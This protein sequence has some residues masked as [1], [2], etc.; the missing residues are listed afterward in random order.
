MINNVRSLTLSYKLWT[1]KGVKNHREF[2]ENFFVKF[3]MV[4]ISITL[5]A[6]WVNYKNRFAF[7][8]AGL[9]QKLV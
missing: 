9:E 4:T 3:F 2:L 8:N 6:F 5:V 1:D 7:A